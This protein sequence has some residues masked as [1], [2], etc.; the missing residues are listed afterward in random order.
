MLRSLVRF[1]RLVTANTTMLVDGVVTAAVQVTHHARTS[2]VAVDDAVLLPVGFDLRLSPFERQPSPSP[3]TAQKRSP[4]E[5]R[6]A[7][8]F[9]G[10]HAAPL[11]HVIQAPNMVTGATARRIIVAQ[12]VLLRDVSSPRG[13]TCDVT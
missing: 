6:R 12:S 11:A 3:D 7:A 8:M 5:P 9:C 1:Y 4:T 10:S 2:S 13:K